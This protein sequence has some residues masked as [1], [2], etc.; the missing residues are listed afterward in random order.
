M[1]ID[2]T[3]ITANSRLSKAR[4]VCFCLVEM[5]IEMIADKTAR[6]IVIKKAP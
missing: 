6:G 5:M 1:T 3:A 4:I 2:I